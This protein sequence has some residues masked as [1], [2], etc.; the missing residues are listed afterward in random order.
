M[1]SSRGTSRVVKAAASSYTCQ[2]RLFSPP[3]APP[4]CS[5]LS[6]SESLFVFVYLSPLAFSF[7][8]RLVFVY[9]TPAVGRTTPNFAA[10][11]LAALSLLLSTAAR[12]DPSR[13][14]SLGGSS[15]IPPP[16]PPASDRDL[17]SRMRGNIAR[18]R[19]RSMISLMLIIA[20]RVFA[21][22]SSMCNQSLAW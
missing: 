18:R 13:T 21:V 11:R 4:R 7:R 8:L 5:R 3:A 1:N 12:K 14:L 20:G 22:S 6:P 9:V 16:F 15:V 19:D 2:P 17:A 10:L